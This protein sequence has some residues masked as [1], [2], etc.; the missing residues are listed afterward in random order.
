MR[1]S[2]H[3][4]R[5][6]DGWELDGYIVVAPITQSAG[7]DLWRGRD[8]STG[9]AV[10]LRRL[11]TSAYPGAAVRRVFAR[12]SAVP[13]VVQARAIVET[14]DATVIVHDLP[15]GGTLSG[16]LDL[17]THVSD[18][19]VVTI[20]V[21]LCNALA[22]AHERGLV[23]GHVD[24]HAVVFDADGCP[25][26]LWPGGADRDD[27]VD[28][29][30]SLRALLTSMLD[31]HSTAA[32]RNA[33][34]A[35]SDANQ[36]AYELLRSAPATPVRLRRP[37]GRQAVVRAPRPVRHA[38]RRLLP[39]LAAVVALIG[40]VAG[41]VSWA[42]TSPDRAPTIPAIASSPPPTVATVAT[43]DWRTVMQQLDTRRDRA[44]A[45]GDADELRLLYVESSTP[46]A[47]DEAA[48]GSLTRRDLRARGLRLTI[49]S[50]TAVKADASSALLHVV[51]QLPA[52]DIVDARGRV[53]AHHPARGLRSWRVELKR[54]GG[55]WRIA[56][57]RSV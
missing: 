1:P 6:T 36:L 31:E 11:P 13:F 26:L 56:T 16:L 52:Y 57:V 19:E 15:T 34:A 45:T 2:V 40:A 25:G 32:L 3:T 18:G 48:L 23:H 38:R 46:L 51:D 8:R 43:V 10:S 14:A 9:G 17:R 33:L 39:V 12:L 22:A 44:F 37:R 24:A 41:G 4:A 27:R 5:V 53:A 20:G 7:V 42:R 50:V 55:A 54:I 49:V 29:T 28:D 35:D 30:R 47:V 21:P